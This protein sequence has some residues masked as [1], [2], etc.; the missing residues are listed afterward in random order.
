MK[1]ILFLLVS[2]VVFLMASDVKSTIVDLEKQKVS[3]ETEKIMREVQKK[4]IETMFEN[5]D[6]VAESQNL[7]Q[8]EKVIFKRSLRHSIEPELVEYFFYLTS[9][10]VPK[11]ALQ[12]FVYGMD[13][14]NKKGYKIIGRVIFNGFSEDKNIMDFMKEYEITSADSTIVNINPF[15]FKDLKISSVPVFVVAECPKKFV[16]AQCEYRYMINGETPLENS[17][18]I[19]GEKDKRYQKMYFDF[20]APE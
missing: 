18:S 14:L 11:S 19:L 9:K 5:L 20:I 6:R 8:E 4:S 12:N 10:S 3:K 15:I 2:L 7:S 17:L 1:K 16:S 13:K